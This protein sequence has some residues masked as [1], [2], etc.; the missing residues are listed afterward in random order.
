MLHDL[1]LEPHDSFQTRDL[2]T[3]LIERISRHFARGTS[4]TA[5]LDVFETTTGLDP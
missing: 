3:F 4:P 5:V 2:R 1:R